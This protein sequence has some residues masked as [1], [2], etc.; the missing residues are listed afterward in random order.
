MKLL[1][2]DNKIT[3]VALKQINIQSLSVQ[4]P[5]FSPIAAMLVRN[6][7]SYIVIASVKIH[8][9]LWRPGHEHKQR[10]IKCNFWVMIGQGTT[11]QNSARLKEGIYILNVKS[12]CY[13]NYVSIALKN[14]NVGNQAQDFNHNRSTLRFL[15]Q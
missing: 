12:S 3:I 11:K 9:M 8:R 15:Y 1:T 2:S 6:R 14:H 5:Q 7:I 10:S 13:I 4:K